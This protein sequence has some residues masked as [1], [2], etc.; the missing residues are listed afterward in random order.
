MVSA[1]LLAAHIDLRLQ[2]DA[3]QVPRAR[4]AVEVF[5]RRGG[6]ADGD[7]RQIGLCVQETLLHIIAHAYGGLGGRPI[8]L[9]GWWHDEILRLTIRDWGHGA[10]PEFQSPRGDGV[11]LGCLRLLMT[12]VRFTA[13]PDGML[14]TLIRRR[15]RAVLGMRIAG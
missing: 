4:R 14:W 8:L 11:G 1:M 6:L 9:E 7:A 5:S 12:E 3:D 13:Q 15:P 10:H 2:S